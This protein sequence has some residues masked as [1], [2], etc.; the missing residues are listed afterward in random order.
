M[1]ESD[2]IA[3][4]DQL[5]AAQISDWRIALVQVYRDEL[6]RRSQDRA[7]NSMLLW[8]RQVRNFTIVILVATI[9]NVAIVLFQTW[10]AWKAAKN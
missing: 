1:S 7:T 10:V 5:L 4:I 6:N 3:K 2:I 8:T 9:V